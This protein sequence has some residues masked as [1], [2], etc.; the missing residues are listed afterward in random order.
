MTTTGGAMTPE[1]GNRGVGKHG[2]VREHDL[3]NAEQREAA[4][5]TVARIEEQ[6]IRTVR[7]IWV[8]QHGAPRCKF[9][10]AVDYISSLD[11]GIDFSAALFNMDTANKLFTPV[12]TEGGGLGIPELTG[13]PDM[14]LV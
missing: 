6:G 5:R 14:V 13:F 1:T 9:M 11:N 7:M 4:M 3:L 8:D 2:F 10:S 12:F